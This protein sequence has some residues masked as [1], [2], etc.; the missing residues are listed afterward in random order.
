MLQRKGFTLIEC[1]VALFIV[2]IV[3]ASASRA[4]GLIISDVHDTFVREVATWVAENEYNLY[5]VNEEYPDVGTVKKKLSLAKIDFNVVE[6]VSNTPNPHF[7]KIDI[8]ISEQNT[9]DYVIF[10]TVVYVAQY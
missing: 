3:L 4:I 7:R 5:F 6:T 10:K 9:P 1:L 8:A 2:T